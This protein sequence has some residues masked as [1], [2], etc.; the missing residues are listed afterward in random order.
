MMHTH[1]V[2]IVQ[3][4]STRVPAV[5]KLCKTFEAHKKRAIDCVNWGMH[6]L[7]LAHRREYRD[8]H[9]GRRRRRECRFPCR[10]TVCIGGGSAFE[11]AAARMRRPLALSR[12]AIWC[13]T[14]TVIVFLVFF[15]CYLF[16]F[17]PAFF[18]CHL[19]SVKIYYK[20]I[21][22]HQNLIMPATKPYAFKSSII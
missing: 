6:K 13:L 8:V 16:N 18:E 19:P 5:G 11:T 21:E 22:E 4:F 2:K 20:T 15:F 9:L 1:T 7:A 12:C 14:R 10:A 17:F 3:R